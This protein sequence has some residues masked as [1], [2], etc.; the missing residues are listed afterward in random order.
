[1]NCR[2]TSY[3]REANKSRE[4]TAAGK[5]I[6]PGTPKTAGTARNVGNSDAEETST[7]IR[8]ARQHQQIV[9]PQQGLFGH[10]Y[11]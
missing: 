4:A 5:P 8:K 10:Q 2:Y 9:K 11:Q 7:A 1:M 3:S 6:T